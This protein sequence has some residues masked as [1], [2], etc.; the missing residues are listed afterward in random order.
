MVSAT[1]LGPFDKFLEPYIK[2]ATGDYESILSEKGIFNAL[3]AEIG[4]IAHE[5]THYFQWVNNTDQSE[6]EKET[7]ADTYSEAI[8]YDYLDECGY[9][10]LNSVGVL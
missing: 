4:S 5:L 1:F 9:D 8:V 7:E 10:F 6:A 3:C 2:V